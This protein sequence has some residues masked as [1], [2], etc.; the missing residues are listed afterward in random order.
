MVGAILSGPKVTI[1]GCIVNI[2]T[3][4][5]ATVP[6]TVL[7]G[8][9]GLIQNN[10]LQVYNTQLIEF[11]VGTSSA[12]PSSFSVIGTTTNSVVNLTKTI[13]NSTF[14]G[15]YYG[16]FNQTTSSNLTLNYS[17]LNYTVASTTTNFSGIYEFISTS[18]V[19]YINVST[20][21]T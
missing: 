12:V 19:T 14:S 10:N 15:N 2:G 11:N 3:T 21:F 20:N 1:S 18:N 6:S 7:C 8:I 17:F 5:G 9:A 13:L 4:A 16:V